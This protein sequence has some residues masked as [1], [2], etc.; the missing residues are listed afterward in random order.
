MRQGNA[1]IIFV[2]IGVNHDLLPVQ[3]KAT[4]LTNVIVLTLLPAGLFGITSM[5]WVK[6]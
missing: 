4:V 3:Y 5:I 2:A 1:P 6:I